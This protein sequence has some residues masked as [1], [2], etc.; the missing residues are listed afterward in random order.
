MLWTVTCMVGEN[1]SYELIQDVHWDDLMCASPDVTVIADNGTVTG[2]V[3]FTCQTDC[4]EGLTFSWIAPNGDRRSSS[5]QYSKNYTHVSTLS[6]KGSNITRL[7][8]KRMC[9]S[10]LNIAPT[11]NG[12]EGMYTCKVKAAH[13]HNA[14]A[15]AVY[16]GVTANDMDQPDTTTTKPSERSTSKYNPL[17]PTT[18]RD[19][20]VPVDD[21]AIKKETTNRGLSTTALIFAGLASSFGCCTI[22]AA[23]A[24][25]T[26]KFQG[27]LQINDGQIDA[28]VDGG[29]E[30]NVM[31]R[32]Y[33]NNDQFSDA[34]GASGGQYEND[35]QF[36][37][38]EAARGGR[39]ENDDQFS[40]T[41]AARGGHY[42]NDDQFS[43]TEAARGGHYENDD[44][45]SDTEAAR[46]G[47]Y[48]NDDQFS[49]TGGLGARGGND[50]LSELSTD[51]ETAASIAQMP[52]HYDNDKDIQALVTSQMF[53][54]YDNE[55]DIEALV[56]AQVP[57]HYDDDKDI[58]AFVKRDLD[59]ATTKDEDSDSDP[60]YMTFPNS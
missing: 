56:T 36:S 16:Q 14:C 50:G 46:G 13:T 51:C 1:G 28:A 39:H 54:H 29:S 6:C 17:R 20:M 4:L 11:G 40:D 31:G 9:Y 22:V 38:T 34:G 57:G 2:N 58:K 52:G 10:V 21:N 5:Y 43:E 37:D 30:N 27:V 35:D 12:T 49:D 53:G 45:F 3:S 8:T 19:E 48:E 59:A 24:A 23:I 15:S 44:Q 47:Q 25:C 32:H 42:E 55:K 7:E 33:E 60:E 18:V 41:E 26:D